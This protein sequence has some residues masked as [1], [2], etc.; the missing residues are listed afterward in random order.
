MKKKLTV[1]CILAALCAPATVFGE[2]VQIGDG[3]TVSVTGTAADKNAPIAI[4]VYANGKTAADLENLTKDE[5]TNILVCHDQGV[6]DA[7]GNYSFTFDIN[8]KSGEYTVLLA[9]DKNDLPSEK[10]I[11]VSLEDYNKIAETIKSDDASKIKEYILN[12][13][14]TIGLTPEDVASVDTSKF[15]A[16]LYE[17]IKTSQFDET[18]RSE[19]LDVVQKA[20][21]VERLNEKKIADVF[22]EDNS[23]TG[24]DDSL[25][26]DWYIKDYVTDDLKKNVNDRISGKDIKSYSEYEEKLIDAYILATVQYPNGS[27]N[28]E[29]IV[30]AFEERIGVDI[31]KAKTSTWTKLAGKNYSTL[32]N[33]KD[34]YKSATSGSSSS[35]GGSSGTGS[36]PSSSGSSNKGINSIV[37]G[38]PI[39]YDKTDEKLPAASFSDIDNVEWAKDAILYLAENGIISGMGDGTFAPNENVNREQFTKI[40]VAAFAED[41]EE[42]EISFK[43]VPDDAWYATYVKKAFGKGIVNGVSEDMFGTGLPITRQD[44]CVMVYKAALETG[45]I[46]EIDTPQELFAD[47]DS[48]AEYAKKAVYALRAN[49]VISG[50]TEDEFAPR[51]NATRAQAA[52]IIYSLLTK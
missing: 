16:V 34:G 26:K 28:I 3:Q 15:A 27:G 17:T 45:K 32:D 41:A 50:L 21:F 4:E 2:A 22:A 37:G 30:T 31:S 5:Y 49:N 52:K 36:K 14:Y 29:D 39:A 48:I 6:T 42:A 20:L 7:E 35:N 24:I 1:I 11:F 9:T 46:I 51:E 43:D 10:L 25:I 12:E 33:L 23:L 19:F 40:V 18:K 44:L 47:D 8:G 38:V 13:T